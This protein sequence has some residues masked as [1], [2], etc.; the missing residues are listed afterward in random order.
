MNA[1]NHASTA[2]GD[3]VW[4]GQSTRHV[5]QGLEEAG[6]TQDRL[7]ALWAGI[8]PMYHYDR[9]AG[10]EARGGDKR[11]LVVY[12]D[13]D[14]TFPRQYSLEVVE[15]FRRYGLNFEARVLP[16]GHYTTGETPYKFIDGWHLGSFVYRA[17]KELRQEGVSPGRERA[18]ES[19]AEENG[20][21]VLR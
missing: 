13:Y 20:K 18:A 8:S 2:F 12:A 14:L 16:C 5:R 9:I 15:A 19:S 17:F 1:F 11:V 6:L 21:P 7:R 10:A 3:V 4:V